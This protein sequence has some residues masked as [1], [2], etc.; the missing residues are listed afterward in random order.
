M[1]GRESQASEAIFDLF[2]NAFGHLRMAG[3]PAI[4][5]GPD[6]LPSQG[7]SSTEEDRAQILSDLSTMT[8]SNESLEI[9]AEVDLTGLPCPEGTHALKVPLDRAPQ[10]PVVITGHELHSVQ[11]ACLQASK[12]LLAGRFAL[13]RRHIDRDQFTLAIAAHRADQQDALTDDLPTLP[14]FL[15]AGVPSGSDRQIGIG[16]CGWGR[17]RQACSRAS[18]PQ[19]G[20]RERQR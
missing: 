5:N 8:P 14:G 18:H 7:W 4:G 15:V 17:S 16:S 19:A 13:R 11:A 9:A 2:L 10:S 1:T 20:T 3:P 6:R 12:D